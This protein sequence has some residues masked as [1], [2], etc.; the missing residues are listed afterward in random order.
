MAKVRTRIAPSPSGPLHVGTARAALFSELYSHGQGGKFIIRIEDTDQERSKPEYEQAILE[1]LKWLGLTWDEGPDIGG[2]FGPYRQSERTESYTAALTKLLDNGTAYTEAGSE[3]I[4]LT[5]EPQ[6]V[7]FNDLIRGEV[8]THSDTWGG[9]FVI[10]RSATDPVFHLAVVVDDAAME[11]SHVIRGEDH[12][13]NTAR[14]ILL[15]RALGLPEPAYAHLPLLMDDQRR[16]LSKRAGDTDLLSYRDQ[17]Y[18][19]E[20]MVNYLALLGWS[21]KDDRE[22]LTH[23]EL[24]KVFSLAGVQKGGAIFSEEKLVAVNKAYLRELSASD[25]LARARN[26]LE[27]AGYTIDDESYWSAA[28]QTEQERVATL[29]ELPAAVEFYKPDWPADYEAPALIWKKS[30]KEATLDVLGKLVEFLS[31][32]AEDSYTAEALE[33]TLMQWIADNQR[34]RGETLWPMRYALTG[35]EHSPGPF[36]VAAVLGRKLTVE[37]LTAAHAKLK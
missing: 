29:A 19:P 23:D 12:L 37:R 17:G 5:V 7:T 13:S 30:T 32:V 16:K 24:L 22:H 3:A 8:T 26:H 10:A 20:A 1:G 34:D 15:Q 33:Q 14:H 31:A 9:D 11:I 25:L 35:R 21:P 18:L 2:D 36:E 28:L 6:E 27:A 4:K